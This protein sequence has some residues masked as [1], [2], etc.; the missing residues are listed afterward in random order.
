MF[1]PYEPARKPRSSKRDLLKV[2]S[3]EKL[4][5]YGGR[6]FIRQYTHIYIYI[7]DRIGFL[8]LFIILYLS[9]RIF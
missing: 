6:S 2:P 7:Y 4:R 5:R 1:Q 9:I 3:P 8:S